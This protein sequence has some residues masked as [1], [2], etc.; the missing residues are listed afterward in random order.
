MSNHLSKCFTDNFP[1]GNDSPA[2]FETFSFPGPNEYGTG[3]TVHATDRVSSVGYL[4][5]A[6]VFK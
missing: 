4:Y 3:V 1:R 5:T 6:Y 2:N